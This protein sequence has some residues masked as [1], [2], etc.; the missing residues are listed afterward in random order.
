MAIKTLKIE[1]FRSITEIEVTLGQLNAF[2]GR[3]NT[4]KS[5]IV[6]AL[7]IILGETWPSRPFTEKDFHKHDTSKP[8]MVAVMFDAPLEYDS[9]VFGFRLTYYGPDQDT[10]YVATDAD[11][12]DLTNRGGYAERVNKTMRDEVVLLFLG[13]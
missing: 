6:H 10:E 2:V 5:N 1:H 13:I 9:E 4:G 11:W 12:K 7:A 3:N 8:I